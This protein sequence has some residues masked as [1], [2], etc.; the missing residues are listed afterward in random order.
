M[1]FNTYRDPSRTY[2]FFSAIRKP[3]EN[4]AFSGYKMV[5]AHPYSGEILKVDRGTLEI[6]VMAVNLH[7]TLMMGDFGHDLIRWCTWIFFLQLLAGVILWWP[8]TRNAL[9]SALRWRWNLGKRRFVFDSHR[10]VGFWASTGLIV[11]VATA[12]VMSWAFIAKPVVSA[13]GGEPSLVHDHDEE[14]VYPRR[15]EGEEFP[16]DLLVARTF[17]QNPAF[18]QV[19][20]SLPFHDTIG[21]VTL[22]THTGDTFLNFAVGSPVEYDRVTG[23]A[24]TGPEADGEARNAKIYAM[25]LLIHMG[26][27][28]GSVTKIL[29]FIIGIAGATLPISGFLHWQGKRRRNRKPSPS[30]EWNESS[31]RVSAEEFERFGNHSLASTGVSQNSQP[32]GSQ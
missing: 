18:N 21:V 28:G 10:V 29:Y 27:W 24:A 1:V 25:N 23:E 17:G 32:T 12:L 6:I 5:Y 11:M 26:F 30:P 13:F 19:T 31:D 16:V 9:I 22:R 15:G 7:T 3:G 8:P 4:L 20:V 14:H 2:D